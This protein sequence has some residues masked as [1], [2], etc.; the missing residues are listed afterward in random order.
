[1]VDAEAAPAFAFGGLEALEEVKETDRGG[2][3]FSW[4]VLD[5]AKFCMA[6]SVS[7]VLCVCV[8]EGMSCLVECKEYGGERT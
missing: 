5:L 1:M 4:E 8:C 2:C 7:E 6:L 3:A